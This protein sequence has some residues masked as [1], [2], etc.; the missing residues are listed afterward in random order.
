MRVML[1]T[2]HPDDH[3]VM[4]GTLLKLKEEFNA[5]I[6]EVTLEKGEGGTADIDTRVKEIK[7]AVKFLGIEHTFLK[8]ANLEG[9]LFESPNRVM[10]YKEEYFFGLIRE[11]R[12]FKPD[13]VFT[14]PPYDYHITHRLAAQITFDA[15]RM[16]MT[17]AF[18]K[19]G[20]KHRVKIVAYPDSIV[21]VKNPTLYF[22]I[23]NYFEKKLYLW[24]EIYKSQYDKSIEDLIVGTALVRAKQVNKKGITKYAE[25]FELWDQK[26]ILFDDIIEMLK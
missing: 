5:Q 9:E 13:I 24:R 8:P 3:I 16:A 11:I 14:L 2:A 18:P 22:D 20:K 10:E 15:V 26:P 19:L 21:L 4:A 1:V 25:A 23:T 7:E 6:K 12:E 17:S